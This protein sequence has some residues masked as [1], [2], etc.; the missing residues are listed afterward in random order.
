M[1]GGVPGRGH[2]VWRPERSTEPGSTVEGGADR[3][4]PSGGAEHST[5]DHLPG[6]GDEPQ[7]GA[8]LMASDSAPRM[9]DQ[10]QET[11]AVI[12]PGYTF[13]SVTDKISTIVLERHVGRRWWIGFAISFALLMVLLY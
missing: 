7:P 9:Q 1:P 4:C 8:G 11:P 2:H 6:G 5:A 13:L 12:G 10:A 3:V